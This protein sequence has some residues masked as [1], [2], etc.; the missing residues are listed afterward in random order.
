M[1]HRAR[2][3]GYRQHRGG[4]T[5][6]VT[7]AQGP[8]NV[9]NAGTVSISDNSSL[10]LLGTNVNSGTVNLN[11]A[12]NVTDLRVSGALAMNGSGVVSLS[13]VTNN[14][15]VAHTGAGDVLSIGSG[16]TVQGAGQ[17]GAGGALGLVNAGTV[18]ANLSNGITLNAQG[19]VT[20]NNVLR[21]D[22][23]TLLIQNTTVNQGASGVLD[24]INNGVVRL[25]GVGITSGTLTTSAGSAIATAGGTTS[26]VSGVTN[27]GTLNI[28]DNSTL[29]LNGTLTNNGSVNMLSVGNTTTISVTGAQTID[30]TGTINLSNTLSNH[31]LGAGATLTL[32]SGQTLQGSGII[33]AG[34]TGFALVNNGT[35]IAT[36]P[37]PLLVNALGGVTN[38]GTMRADG[39]T[40]QLQTTMNSGGGAIE[41]RNGSQVQLLNGAVINNANFSASGANSLITTV[42]GS[43]VT[44]GGGTI[45]GP[46]TINDNSNLVLAANATYNGTLSLTSVGNVTSLQ[47]DGTR[48]LTGA[49]TVQLSNTTANQIRGRNASGDSLVIDSGIT[50]QGSGIIGAGSAGFALTNSGTL[51]ATQS[52]PLLVNALGG[53][54]NTGTLR[55]DGGTLQLQTTVESGGGAIEALNGSQV[56]L[57]NG[58]V[59]NNANF[60]A[61]GT[62]SLITTVGGSTVTLGGGTIAG[63]M[64]IAD[65]SNLVLAA[66][67]TY[68]GTLSLA[69]VGNVTSLQID[70]AR[71]L[72]G[73]ATVQMLNTT[74]NQIKGR[75]AS[76]DSLVINSGIT[77]QGA[78][79][80][81][82]NNLS[83]VNN[84][85]LIAT[86]P[87]GHY[88]QQRWNGHQQQR[89]T[90]RRRSVHDRR[91]QP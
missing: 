29:T 77:V 53:V 27:N 33:G 84:G 2:G 19:G 85:S 71:S 51:I 74:A 1:R 49:A 21:G 35:L 56:Q 55:A 62:N 73:T 88:A 65:N 24:A 23:A 72:T 70:G 7:G 11:S 57:L 15:I 91:H 31:I 61:S 64:T 39:G 46:M 17:I 43:T 52:Q 28:L 58:A 80:I 59:I 6:T 50:V 40:L 67:A 5:S 75:N 83:L 20:N 66:D 12:G 79:I 4:Q 36:Q 18:V 60:S 90:G 16:Q 9:S 63:P 3:H 8:T 47:I 87:C 13:N 26:S 69:S 89:D 44:L 76:G 37:S 25:S 41:A 45:A 86:Q 38:T 54:T 10:V 82:G 68:N 22:G 78:G 30:G 81:G 48:S 42:G 32:G 14:R 34:S